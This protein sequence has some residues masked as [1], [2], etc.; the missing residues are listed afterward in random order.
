MNERPAKLATLSVLVVWASRQLTL[1]EK[2]VWYRDWTLDRGDAD[3]CYASAAGLSESLGGSVTPRSV[4]VFRTRLK[5]LGLH[6]AHRRPEGRNTGWIATLP[7]DCARPRTA[8]EAMA[9][10]RIL[11]AHIERLDAGPVLTPTPVVV[12]RNGGCGQTPAVIAQAPS[13]GLGGTSL[14][15]GSE[16]PLPS[17]VTE[18]EEKEKQKGEVRSH[19]D[20]KRGGDPTS[21]G[22]AAAS[23]LKRRGVA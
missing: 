5:L 18:G 1:G 20:E 9:M 8:K 2:V 23:Y 15:E 16:T 13:G 4:E 19:Q 12:E 17:V 11:D 21:I 6:Q 3:G 22:D 14:L 7:A 10:A